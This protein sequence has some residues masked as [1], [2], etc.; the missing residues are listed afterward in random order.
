MP[1]LVDHD[2]RRE[3]IVDATWRLIERGG[4]ERATMR[5]IASEAGFAHGAL[6]RYFHNKESLLAAAFVRAHTRTNERAASE[7][8]K[9]RG[10]AALRT[11]CL[12]IIPLGRRGVQEARVVVAFWD[13]AI[14]DED[15]WDAHREN[16]LRWRA[17]M[18]QFLSEARQDGEIATTVDDQ[19]IVDQITAMNAGLQILSLLM[20]ETTT[21]ERQ[22][23][24]LDAFLAG[25]KGDARV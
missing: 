8:L 9:E 13:R 12:E 22:L 7:L 25:L 20:P 10:L 15:L 5:E 17:Q 11:L 19:V 24:V 18:H 23:A 4:F 14:V 16:A 21:R 3:L 1:K 2:E 6:S